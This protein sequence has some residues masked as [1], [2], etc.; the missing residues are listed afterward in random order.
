LTLLYVLLSRALFLTRSYC[1]ALGTGRIFIINFILSR[2]RPL[3]YCQTMESAITQSQSIPI[4]SP[5]KRV[6]GGGMKTPRHPVARVLFG[7]PDPV[8]MREDLQRSIDAANATFRERWNFDPV[9]GR[10]CPLKI[11]EGQTEEEAQAQQGHRYIWTRVYPPHEDDA[12]EEEDIQLSPSPLRRITRSSS[13]VT[14]TPSDWAAI[15]IQSHRRDRGQTS[16]PDNKKSF[17]ASSLNQRSIKGE[18][19]LKSISFHN[20]PEMGDHNFESDSANKILKNSCIL[21]AFRCCE[22]CFLPSLLLKPFCF[23]QG[24]TTN[25]KRRE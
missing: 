10:P 19:H 1:T 3:T 21:P 15:Q 24:K 11:R 16:S 9:S 17:V 5:R 13:L 25:E 20:K 14:V 6:I 2:N 23:S 18:S 22:F 7:Y 12:D 8:K 4:P